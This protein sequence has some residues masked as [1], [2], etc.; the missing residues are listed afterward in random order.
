MTDDDEGTRDKIARLRDFLQKQSA[1]SGDNLSW[2]ADCLTRFLTDEAKTL[3][4]AFGLRSGKRGPKPMQSG[5][6]DDWVV[7]AFFEVTKN[8]PPGEEWPNTKTLAGIG[9]Y[10]GLGGRDNEDTEDHAIASEIKK[11]L[12]RYKPII[13]RQL[14][15]E[16]SKRWNEK[17]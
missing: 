1:F 2:A 16:I 15:E 6:H 7:S 12:I 11:I 5:E 10:Y 17:E 13:I 9:R 14:N 3:D 8:T 4:H